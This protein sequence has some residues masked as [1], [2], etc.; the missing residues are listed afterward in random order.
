MVTKQF[1]IEEPTMY[2]RKR[3]SEN[4][5]GVIAFLIAGFTRN[6]VYNLRIFVQHTVILTGHYTTLKNWN[7]FN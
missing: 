5:T 3:Q 2:V 1:S 7:E 4:K 6:R